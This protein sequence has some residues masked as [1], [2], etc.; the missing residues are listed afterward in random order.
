MHGIMN[1]LSAKITGKSIESIIIEAKELFNEIPPSTILSNKIGLSPK[2]KLVDFSYEWIQGE[3]KELLKA[4]G[5]IL[6]SSSSSQIIV[7]SLVLTGLM[8][9][10]VTTFFLLK[11]KG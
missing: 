1:G 7:P 4:N 6:E 2:T 5:Q 11:S 8:V 3:R 10:G 9:V